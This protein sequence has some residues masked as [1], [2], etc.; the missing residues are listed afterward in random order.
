MSWPTHRITVIALW[1]AEWW[2]LGDG[3]VIYIPIATEIDPE[4]GR[5]IARAS[6][7]NNE[8]TLIDIAVSGE[9]RRPGRYTIPSQARPGGVAT[10]TQVIKQ[11]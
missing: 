4:M 7:A 9:V 5:Q 8:A 1:W 10:I 2:K 3:D 11:A 6:F